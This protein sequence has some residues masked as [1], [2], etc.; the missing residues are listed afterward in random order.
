[1]GEFKGRPG[2]WKLEC[3]DRNHRYI[4]VTDSDDRTIIYKYGAAL[5]IESDLDEADGRLIASAPA[6]L[7][8][9]TGLLFDYESIMQSGDCGNGGDVS[10]YPEIIK[11]RAAIASAVGEL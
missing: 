11:A 5:K 8:A 9:L 6:L 10:A 4:H 1:M 7:E 2:P 3:G